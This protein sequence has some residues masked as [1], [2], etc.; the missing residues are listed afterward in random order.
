[1][2]IHKI[3]CEDSAGLHNFPNLKWNTKCKDC[4]KTVGKIVEEDWLS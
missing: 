2:K 4:G 1:M 3:I